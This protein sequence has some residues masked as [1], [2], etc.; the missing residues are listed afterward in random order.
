M[1][2]GK[3]TKAIGARGEKIAA[4]Y[5]KKNGYKIIAKNFFSAHGEIDIIAKRGNTLV[6]VEVKSRKDCQ[7]HFENYGLPSEAVTKTK[8]QHIIYTARKFLES[9]HA[10]SE[11][12]FDIIEVYLGVHPRVHHIEDAF[13]A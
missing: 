12:R 4:R 5:L 13:F 9:H 1:L 7:S 2:F 11:I 3:T 8:Q 10:D 6:F